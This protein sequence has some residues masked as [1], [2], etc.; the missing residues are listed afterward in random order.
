M[1]STLEHAAASVVIVVE[2]L[3]FFHAIERF[4]LRSALEVSA[5]AVGWVHITIVTI[6]GLRCLEHASI[7]VSI[8]VLCPSL[9]GLLHAAG[10]PRVASKGLEADTASG[11]NCRGL[12]SNIGLSKVVVG[13]KPAAA[14]SGG[15]NRVD[16]T[17]VSISV[18]IVVVVSI[19]VIRTVSSTCKD[20]V[21]SVAHI[22]V[23]FSKVGAA[24]EQIFGIVGFYSE[25]I[26][27]VGIPVPG[28]S[29][30]ALVLIVV[31]VAVG[32]ATRSGAPH[33]T[34]ARVAVAS[35]IL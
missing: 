10:T 9:V 15:G 33:F 16:D 18:V 3:I 31:V 30:H 2:R 23:G 34:N 25:T 4:R 6:V 29:S 8:I 21:V 19:R 11:N 17:F 12:A 20:A 35:R 32:V 1:R 28:R 22:V 27:R 26:K 5:I 14:G 24:L 7:V 13:D